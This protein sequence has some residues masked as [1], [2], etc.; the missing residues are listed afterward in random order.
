VALALVA[1]ASWQSPAGAARRPSVARCDGSWH[2][3][4]TPANHDFQEFNALS[5]LSADD[6]W[7][8]GLYGDSGQAPPD[9]PLVDHWDGS[10]WT[11]VDGADLAYGGIAYG[12]VTLSATN[13]WM[14]G[15]RYGSPNLTPIKPLIEHWIGSKWKMA[16]T[17]NVWRHH[18]GSALTGIAATSSTDVWAVGGQTTGSGDQ[19]L[20]E[21]Y[22]GTAWSRVKAIDP[23]GGE[24]SFTGVTAVA[25]D[26]AW[27]VG[28]MSEGGP[29]RTLIEHWDGT[30]WSVIPSPN[31]SEHANFLRGVS[32]ASSTDVWAVGDYFLGSE[33]ITL[34]EHWDGSEWTVVPSKH[35][36]TSSILFGVSA[37]ADGTVWAVGGWSPGTPPSL[38]LTERWAGSD[39]T[40]V[41]GRSPGTDYNRLYGVS[42]LSSGNVFAGGGYLNSQESVLR[43][44]AE[45]YC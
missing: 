11:E 26:D 13:A 44:L 16:R 33:D 7:A 45:H 8:V 30:A 14:S 29:A 3:Q 28:Y 19:T 15:E 40:V 38:V 43:S 12:V 21:H 23:P 35:P 18:L 5:A 42:A 31:A 25:P 36:G 41:K 34:T 4:V 22:D 9:V 37:V 1:V 32:A 2:L 20:V 39:W 24:T 10:A 6:A 17:P 27:A